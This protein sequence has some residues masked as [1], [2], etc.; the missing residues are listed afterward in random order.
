MLQ[1]Y[2]YNGLDLC[3]TFGKDC[4]HSDDLHFIGNWQKINKEYLRRGYSHDFLPEDI[5]QR[6][7]S[8]ATVF[9]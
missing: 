3:P 6:L 4:I 8:I 7:A 1:Y 5:K 2:H 9:E